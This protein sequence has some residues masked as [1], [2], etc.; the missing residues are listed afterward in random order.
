MPPAAASACP[1]IGNAGK[2]ITQWPDACHCFNEQVRAYQHDQCF[3]AGAIKLI[4][5]GEKEKEHRIDDIMAQV[6]AHGHGNPWSES[7]LKPVFPVTVLPEKQENTGCQHNL[8]A[9][10]LGLK[11]CGIF[12]S[13][14]RQPPCADKDHQEIHTAHSQQHRIGNVPFQLP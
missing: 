13:G 4:C 12:P 6:N 8:K 2:Q 1:G 5:Y 9:I 10:G 7:R 11:G 3:Q 14:N